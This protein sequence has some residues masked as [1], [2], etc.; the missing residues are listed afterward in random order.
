VWSAP[1]SQLT[2]LTGHDLR[3]QPFPRG[4]VARAYHRP[5]PS[6]FNVDC[7]AS[8]PT[9][10]SATELSGRWAYGDD[11][12]TFL[13]GVFELANDPIIKFAIWRW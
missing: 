8:G 11:S 1:N 7:A 12:L 5:S 3:V 2:G 6:Q 4:A 13:L 10:I 9:P